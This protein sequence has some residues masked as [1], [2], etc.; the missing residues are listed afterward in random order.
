MTDDRKSLFMK[1][2]FNDIA[3]IGMACIFPG[4][5]DFKTYWENILNKVDSISEAPEG[6]GA[7][8]Y[9]DPDSNAND[10]V[11]TN[12]GGFIQEFAEFNPLEFG[13]IPRSI[14]GS[15]PFHFLA[16]KVAQ[17]TFIDAGYHERSFNKKK[18]GV[19]LGCYT[20]VNL[21]ELNIIQHGIVVDQTLSIV[22]QLFPSVSKKQFEIIKQNLKDHLPP[23]NAETAPGAIS[24][25]IGARIA[26]RL[27]LQ[28][29]NYIVNAACSSSIIALDQGIMEL[30]SGRCD[31]VLVG[32][33]Q[34]DAKAQLFMLFC[35]LSALSKSGKIRPFDMNADG[36]LLSEGIGMLL[37]KRLEDAQ[38]DN[39]RIYAVIKGVGIASDG[40]AKG[41]LVPRLEGEILSIERAY[42]ESGI[43]PESIGLIEAH[44]TGTIVGDPVEINALNHVFA[45]PL[46]QIQSCPL[47]SVKSMIGHTNVAAGMASVI[48]T[49]LALYHKILPPTLCDQPNPD[50][51]LDKTKF[52]LNTESQPW[53]HGQSHPRRAA[54]NSFGFGGI[55]THIILE[56][57]PEENINNKVSGILYKWDSEVV[58]LQGKSRDDLIDSCNNL[59]RML[60][61]DP[62]L[63]L[64][65]VAYRLNTDLEKTKV[66]R[67]A[68]I[69]ASVEELAT[70]L[71]YAL[72]KI[73]DHDC[74]TIND[75]SGIYFFAE[76]L[77]QTGKLAFMFPGEGS[78]YQGMLSG[79]CLHFPE[80]RSFFDR[81]DKIFEA[82]KRHSLPS[83][84]LFPPSFLASAQKKDFENRLFS[85]EYARPVMYAASQAIYS[86]LDNLSIHPHALVGHSSGEDT[87]ALISGMLRGSDEEAEMNFFAEL[88]RIFHESD[89]N[90]PEAHLVAVGAVDH[91][92]V[93]KIAE[94]NRE[95]LFVTMD[96]C[97]NQ[98]V[99]CGS[100][101][102]IADARSELK[103]HGAVINFL[104]IGR[105]YHTP[106]CD[107]NNEK[108]VE[109]L[110]RLAIHPPAVDV[111]SCATGNTFPREPEAIR[112]LLQMQWSKPVL[113]R[114]TIEN[115]YDQGIRTFVEVGPG[116]ILS[117]FVEDILAGRP[118]C[119]V[120]TDLKNRSSTTQLNHL[121]GILAAQGHFLNFDYLYRNRQPVRLNTGSKQKSARP[122]SKKGS[123]KLNLTPRLLS[124]D[125]NMTGFL[126]GSDVSAH[127]I[128]TGDA[129]VR[130]MPPP[131]SPP[132]LAVDKP[133]HNPS[134][135]RRQL[136]EEHLRT[137]EQF[138][139][140]QQK[141]MQVVIEK[142]KK[143]N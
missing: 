57:Y 131:Q 60:S 41:L 100:E 82:N 86:L 56:E 115:M 34:G 6:W 54:I 125:E 47:G 26:N 19:I 124:L 122:P 18:T 21:A 37:I 90:I 40:K 51:E 35:Q 59:L 61:V 134:S 10:R 62:D 139:A 104:P 110:N 107:A 102:V 93:Y 22:K 119:V 15:D 123:I 95:N 105:A 81:A 5:P 97:P 28:G 80:L 4:A 87:A 20:A 46:E 137:M 138:L 50:L 89:E 79:L 83:Q 72:K 135:P 78:Q 92:I 67:L 74:A 33:V 143:Q 85:M 130:Q 128:D 49:T 38:R 99:L 112:E 12:R 141:V 108:G 9:Y 27:D 126:S 8:F 63:E 31:M 58:I 24:N 3:I 113:F 96:N 91:S 71:A 66:L 36:T 70:K 2:R 68:I 98:I 52:F 25:I 7:E 120:Q 29:P 132:E 23:F 75:R 11:Y 32:G 133:I 136:V 14:E 17:D 88:G 64:I 127:E 69:A 109:F 114:K 43:E 77:G 106:L 84:L 116:G 121:V 39:D 76:Q 45:H 94:K 73:K 55:N 16:L 13:T 103:K 65:N 117:S 48:K 140:T 142:K 30:E 44:G 129:P 42:S 118:H 53:I 1:K 101:E 111:Y